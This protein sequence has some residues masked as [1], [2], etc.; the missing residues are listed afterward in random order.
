MNTR[1]ITR[2]ADV[3]ARDA[4]RQI[5][6]AGY[7]L[8]SLALIDA[9][10]RKVAAASA[11]GRSDLQW[12]ATVKVAEFPFD[13]DGP[14]D[15]PKDDAPEGGDEPKDDAPDDDL[16]GGDDDEPSEPESSEPKLGEVF[17]LLK[18]IAEHFQ[19]PVPGDEP[20]GPEGDDLGLPPVDG[21]EGGDVPPAG[22]EELPLPVEK[23]APGAGG[24]VFSHIVVANGDAAKGRRSFV[25]CVADAN[26]LNDG[27]IVKEAQIAFPGYRVAGRID[28][29]TLANSNEA[30]VPLTV[31][32]KAN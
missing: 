6:G 2:P 19:I 27:E 30:R 28:R 14:A 31:N 22:G 4:K 8:V 16:F 11:V 24:G 13:K 1:K 12:E 3:T 25:A 9:G 32:T 29:V 7:E 23:K 15:E 18:A 26:V 10:G 5:R 17:D 21:P 20:I